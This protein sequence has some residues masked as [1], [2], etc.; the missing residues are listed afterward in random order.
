MRSFTLLALIL[1]LHFVSFAD[2]PTPAEKPPEQPPEATPSPLPDGA[3]PVPLHILTRDKFFQHFYSIGQAEVDNLTSKESVDPHGIYRYWGV[4]GYG[5]SKPGEGLTKLNRALLVSNEA[6]YATFYVEAPKKLN[7]RVKL[8]HFPIW[9][10]EKP[11]PGLVPVYGVSEDD[12]RNIRFMTDKE[13]LKEARDQAYKSRKIRLKN[14]GI[15]FYIMP[16]RP[17][18]KTAPKSEP[19]KQN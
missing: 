16:A 5:S 10:W 4:L 14:H 2:D 11:Q 8:H 3:K 6:T 18:G 12:W 15:M 1:S 9:V 17:A 7:P 13:T 19:D